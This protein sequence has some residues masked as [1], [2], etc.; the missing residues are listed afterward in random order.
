VSLQAGLEC[1][2]MVILAGLFASASAV[3]GAELSATESARLR[4]DS[5][6]LS[7]PQFL[8]DAKGGQPERDVRR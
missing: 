7:E 5:V 4:F 1:Y 6:T 2:S 3:A 8:T